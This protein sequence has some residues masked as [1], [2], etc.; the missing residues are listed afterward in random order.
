MHTSQSILY[1]EEEG[2]KNLPQ[3]LR[4]V[5]RSFSKR[6]DLRACKIVVFT[7]IGEGPAL[8]YNLL[9]Q[10]DPKIIAVTLPPDFSVQRGKERLFPRIPDKLKAFFSGVGVT[11]ITGRLPFDPIEG[12]EAHNEQMVLVRNVI[13]IFGGGFALCVQAVLQACDHGVIEPGEKVI[14][15]AGDSA[16]VFTASMTK[17]FLSRDSGLAINEVLCKARNFTIAR[18]HPAAAVEQTRNLFEQNPAVRLKSALPKPQDLLASNSEVVQAS[19]E[20]K[21]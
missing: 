5:K 14:S 19:G 7:A 15:V 11:V 17:N 20:A 1:F 10:Y 6:A 12:C 18:G 8:A 16:G 4:V 2:R 9:Q 3:V 13:S 21:K